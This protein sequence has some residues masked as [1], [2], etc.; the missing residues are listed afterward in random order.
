[1]E[2]CHINLRTT[3][4]QRST[5]RK[6]SFEET[7]KNTKAAT[8]TAQQLGDANRSDPFVKR[9]LWQQQAHTPNKQNSQVRT[10]AFTACASAVAPAPPTLLLKRF[11]SVREVFAL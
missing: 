11:S 10:V 5:A 8:Q 6:V 9:H 3:R 4:E 7:G 2:P 1:M